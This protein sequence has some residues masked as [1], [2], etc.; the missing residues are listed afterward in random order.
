MTDVHGPLLPEEL[1]AVQTFAKDYGREWKR[2]LEAAWLSHSYKGLPMGGRDTG[3]LRYLR[4]T[5][6]HE[7]LAK[8]KLPKP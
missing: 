4:N 2:Y 5:R 6:G 7:W 8:F 3:T 1:A